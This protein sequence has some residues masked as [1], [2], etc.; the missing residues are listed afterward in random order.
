MLFNC[1]KHHSAIKFE[2]RFVFPHSLLKNSSK[3]HFEW[4]WLAIPEKHV[5]TAT[6]YANIH[7]FWSK[8]EWEI[9]K[10]KKKQNI[11]FLSQCDSFTSSFLQL[12]DQ[13]DL[14]NQPK[15]ASKKGSVLTKCDHSPFIWSSTL[16]DINKILFCTPFFGDKIEAHDFQNRRKTTWNSVPDVF[17]GVI[18][19][20]FDALG[21][22]KPSWW[23]GKKCPTSPW[24]LWLFVCFDIKQQPKKFDEVVKKKICRIKTFIWFH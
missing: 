15:T 17:V 9:W 7:S 6:D 12:F 23:G 18:L 5:L 3:E 13:A 11:K 1:G 20:H 8:I 10:T 16:E 22:C 2:K 4:L 21:H 14:G 19:V 24:S